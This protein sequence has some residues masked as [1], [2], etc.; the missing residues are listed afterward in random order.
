MKLLEETRNMTYACWPQ[1]CYSHFMDYTPTVILETVPAQAGQ[2]SYAL[3]S[4]ASYV[5]PTQVGSQATSSHSAAAVPPQG[6]PP[7]VAAPTGIQ[8]YATIASGKSTW[9]SPLTTISS[10]EWPRLSLERPPRRPPAPKRT[11]VPP[12]EPDTPPTAA[13]T[14]AWQA[15][16]ATLAASASGQA[17]TL[18]LQ[19]QHQPHEPQAVGYPAAS[20]LQLPQAPILSQE[21]SEAHVLLPTPPLAEDM[22]NPFR[23]MRD[24]V[25]L[26]SPS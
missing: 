12:A 22:D 9:S 4:F 16:L 19:A 6:G 15:T 17:P 18:T 14:A 20:A 24:Q 3:S 25:A 26:R 2:S 5:I 11:Y 13:D 21:R 1:G 7:F 10:S 8:T 23:G